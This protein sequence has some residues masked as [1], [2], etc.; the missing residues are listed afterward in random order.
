MNDGN[1]TD[2][3]RLIALGLLTLFSAGGCD[4]GRAASGGIITLPTPETLVSFLQDF[5]RQVLAAY[6]F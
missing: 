1:E 2:W 3:R 6:L 4:A 5:A